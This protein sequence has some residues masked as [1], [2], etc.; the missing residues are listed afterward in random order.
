MTRTSRARLFAATLAAMLA[1]LASW[2]DAPRILAFGDS[3][4]AGYGLP[5]GKG[6]VPQ[7]QAWL[8]A[9]GIEA[10]VIDA[11][12]SGDTTYGGRVR[13]PVSIR[14]H[15]HRVGRVAAD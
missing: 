14:R 12:L 1:P 3:L 9:R 8:D 13:L 15:D 7:L 5:A 6:L 10:T 2:A 11:G 4:T